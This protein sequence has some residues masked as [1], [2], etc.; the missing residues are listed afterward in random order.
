M[1]LSD[2]V[3]TI[4]ELE[5]LQG[6]AGDHFEIDVFALEEFE[7]LWNLKSECLAVKS[8]LYRLLRVMDHLGILLDPK[9]RLTAED[10]YEVLPF[11][12]RQMICISAL[13]V[14]LTGL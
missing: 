12:R 13:L 4:R 3:V 5:V 7:H 1:G 14:A 11:T 8:L 2:N 10:Y 9:S 6:A